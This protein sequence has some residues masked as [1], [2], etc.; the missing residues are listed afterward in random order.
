[1]KML[2]KI[3]VVSTF[4]LFLGS[5][6]FFI[7][8]HVTS[9]DDIASIH[10]YRWRSIPF[11]KKALTFFAY[12]S[13][14][15]DIAHIYFSAIKAKARG[16]FSA[17]FP[18]HN[19]TI[20][21]EDDHSLGG[22]PKNDDWI[23]GASYLDKTFLRNNISYQLF[24]SFDQANIAPHCSYVNLYRNFRYH[25][26]YQLTERIDAKRLNLDKKDSAACI[27]KEPPIF[28]SPNEMV[29]SN[30][31]KNKDTYHQKYPSKKIKDYT[32][33][34]E[35]LRAFIAHSPDSL[36][37]H[38]ETGIAK[39]LDLKNIMDWHILLLITHNDDG[40]LKNFYLYKKNDSTP[41]RICPWDYDHSFGRDGDGEPHSPGIIDFS[42]NPLIQRLTTSNANHYN[43]LLA[44][45]FYTLL[46]NNKITPKKVIEQISSEYQQI[47]PFVL[48][49]EQRWPL[50]TKHLNSSA[51]AD[52]EVAAMKKWYT[53]QLKQCKDYIDNLP[54]E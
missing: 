54:H 27:F 17:D 48:Q 41:F 53:E 43:D 24:R 51:S 52:H 2:I 11:N 12:H 8:P 42:S 33:S 1:M 47:R 4:F 15:T 34:L 50:N 31:T 18:K 7:H 20:K 39:Y 28:N 19:Y 49:N 21:L 38:P 26:L 30:P 6:F 5:I 37:N 23:L 22:L 46:E 32:N 44:A 14:T 29:N 9:N 45:R 13:N 3:I 25:G 16:G 35:K 36:F 40:L 10:F